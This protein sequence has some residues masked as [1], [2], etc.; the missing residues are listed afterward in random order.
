MKPSQG[1]ASGTLV[2][3]TTG[4]KR[5][6]DVQIG[7]YLYDAGNSPTLRIGVALPAVD[8]L[9][10][11]DHPD[12]ATVHA[13]IETVLDQHY[14]TGHQD[15]SKDIDHYLQLLANREL[16][17]AP[18]LDREA[19][20][21]I[22][23]AMARYLEQLLTRRVEAAE[24]DSTDEVFEI[25]E[26]IKLTGM[27][28]VLRAL[29]LADPANSSTG[30][31][32]LSRAENSFPEKLFV[33]LYLPSS[34]STHTYVPS[35]Q[36]PPPDDAPRSSS[37]FADSSLDS[38]AADGLA[39]VLKSLD[40]INCDWGGLRKVHRRFMTGEQAQPVHSILLGDHHHLVDPLIISDGEEFSMTV[41]NSNP[42]PP[43]S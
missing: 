13:Y 9:N 1:L 32:N 11:D 28:S 17:H 31:P 6:V 36:P 15:Y 30:D 10:G 35:S 43:H 4:V 38:A 18:G 34:Q 19:R 33:E 5:V 41:V 7:D 39:A 26:L 29:T 12:P 40:S 21:A 8:L 20:G 22:H 3:T 42:V 27:R 14:H 37:P 25:D 24:V 23:A 16:G 2:R